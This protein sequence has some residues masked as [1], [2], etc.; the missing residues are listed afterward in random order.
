MIEDKNPWRLEEE[1]V[2]KLEFWINQGTRR[3]KKKEKFWK[4]WRARERKEAFCSFIFKFNQLSIDRVPI[5]PSKSYSSKILKISFG[6]KL[7]SLNWKTHSI[8]RAQFEQGRTKL[9]NLRRF[10]SVEEHTRLIKNLEKL[11][12]WKTAGVLCR[13]HSNQL[14]SW[15]KCMSMSFKVFQ[16]TW[17]QPRSSKTRLWNILSPKFNQWTYFVSKSKN[18]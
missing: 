16:N 7:G 15:I 10:W 8:D 9:K 3:Q 17:I 14:I 2:K 1:K 5:K 11:N 6:W 4:N 12:F 18:I 13:K